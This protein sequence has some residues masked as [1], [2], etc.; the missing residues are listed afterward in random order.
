MHIYCH[1]S[2]TLHGAIEPT[3]S[4]TK[5]TTKEGISLLYSRNVIADAH[6]IIE[7]LRWENAK[8]YSYW[9]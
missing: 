8:D 5:E 4:I 1:E 3:L 2:G 6:H 7:R 9:P